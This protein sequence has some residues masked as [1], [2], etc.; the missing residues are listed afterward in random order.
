MILHVLPGDAIVEKFE[1]TGLEGDVAV[2]REALVDGDLSGETLPEFW[3]NRSRFLHGDQADAETEYHEKV[4]REFNKLTALQSGSEINLWFEYELFCHANMWFCLDLI[5]NTTADVYRIAPVTLSDE[6]VWDGFAHMS[7]DDMRRC[8]ESR[9]GLSTADIEVGSNLWSAYKRND[10]SELR[11]LSQSDSPAF[12][13][14]QEVCA[15]AI[16]RETRPKAIVAEIVESGTTDFEDVFRVF[17]DRAGVYG[18][19][20]TQVKRIWQE[21][22]D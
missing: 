12:P 18:F 15:A 8:F 19:G 6:E 3:E 20:D 22:L 16:E 13:R 4:V 11:R 7:A 5:R 14:L 21:L 9:V 10:V 17:R 2:C 1:A